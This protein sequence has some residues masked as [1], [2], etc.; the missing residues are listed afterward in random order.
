MEACC[1]LEHY[2]FRR[3]FARYD[4]FTFP[5]LL[6]E[7][8]FSSVVVICTRMAHSDESNAAARYEQRRRAL[9]G[10]NYAHVVHK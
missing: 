2:V 10:A 1:Y 6:F 9:D 8:C 3:S 5:A 4:K 7:F